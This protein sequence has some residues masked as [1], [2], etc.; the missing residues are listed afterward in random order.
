MTLHLQ[1]HFDLHRPTAA[2][3]SRRA[4]RRLFDTALYAGESVEPAVVDTTLLLVS[5]LVTNA[6]R[7]TDGDCSLD[8]EFDEDGIGIDVTDFSTAEPRPRRPDD[9]GGGGWGWNL[10][11]RLGSDVAIRHREGGKTVHVRVPC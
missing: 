8:L 7:H 6:V 3:D 4:A 2:A 9:R 10:V 11:N 5:E 1:R